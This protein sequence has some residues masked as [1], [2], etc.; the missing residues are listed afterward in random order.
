MGPVFCRAFTRSLA[1]NEPLGVLPHRLAH[2]YLTWRVERKNSDS[3]AAAKQKR[4]LK[5]QF[6]SCKCQY[7]GN[8]W[9]IMELRRHSLAKRLG[10]AAT[11]TKFRSSA[12]FLPTV[13][14]H[15][16]VESQDIY[17]LGNEH[18]NKVKWIAWQVFLPLP[19]RSKSNWEKVSE[20]SF[21]GRK[22]SS[23][24][25]GKERLENGSKKC[26]KVAWR[27][28]GC[29]LCVCDIFKCFESWRGDTRT[30]EVREQPGIC[31]AAPNTFHNILRGRDIYLSSSPRN[32]YETP[33]L[34]SQ[35]FIM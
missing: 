14:P 22:S 33:Y 11:V 35:I 29:F 18:K 8:Y 10:A 26:M 9:G 19:R 3:K 7:W 30:S 5:R 13:N 24:S 32:F 20:R 23:S 1:H 34:W 25:Q 16:Y 27:R 17:F 6:S 28:L 12:T 15:Y 31:Y 2:H 4:G 21:L